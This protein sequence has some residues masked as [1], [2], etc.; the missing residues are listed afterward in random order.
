MK[1][2]H[3]AYTLGEMGKELG[4]M[5]GKISDKEKAKYEA[6]AKKDKERYEKEKAKV[7]GWG[8]G[9]LR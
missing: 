8:E 1:A 2:K 4:A 6:E 7:R 5:W 9:A 3:P